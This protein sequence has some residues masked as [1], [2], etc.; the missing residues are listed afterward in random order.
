MSDSRKLGEQERLMHY[1]HPYG[2]LMPLQ[3]MHIRGPVSEDQVTRA[4]AWLQRQHPMLRAHVRY[5]GL[6][7]RDLPPFVYRQ[8]R[9]ET[10]GTFTIPF[11]AVTGD[12][13]EIMES[14]LLK[15]IPLGRTPRLRATLVHDA[16]DPE[17][18]HLIFC[19]DHAVVDAIAVHMMSRQLLE[20][21]ADP[22]AME[23]TAPKYTTLPP[24]LETGMPKKSNSGGRGYEPALR[25][26][27]QKV[28]GRRR[29]TKMI[30]HTLDK[31]TTDALKLAVKT[32]RTTLHGA[33]SAAFL[34]AMR[35]RYGIDEM[36][37]VSS[38]DLRRLCKPPLPADTFG[39]YIDVLR[40]RH[41]LGDDL[42]AIAR[43]VSFKL[44]S[45]IARDQEVSSF[46]KLPDWEVYRKETW[47]T[48]THNR[49][50]DGLGITTANDSGLRER[51][52]NH[53]LEGVSMAV[54]LDFTGPSLL[55][56][57]AERMGAMDISACY[58]AAALPDEDARDL[59]ARA[60]RAL[61]QAAAAVPA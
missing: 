2:G 17:L 24:A 11:R 30:E 18:C 28:K 44:I 25:L 13:R 45:A 27:R 50:L 39:C 20:Y 49:R 51:Y 36:T 52:G 31:A 55:V 33:M 23:A 9:F 14:E 34:L 60:V 35:Q 54:G 22:A 32:H 43:D 41:D 16:A 47:P 53:I 4:L 26:P 42:W 59:L 12:W 38:V 56:L 3:V 10:E 1:M 46:L 19:A 37:C 21:L 58:A 48:M 8:P 40:T 57:A 29:G 6:V 5:G 61:E 15:P 7:F